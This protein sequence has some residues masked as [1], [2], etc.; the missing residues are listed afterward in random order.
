ML[1]MPKEEPQQA[2]V[3]VA[4]LRWGI[5]TSSTLTGSDAQ[6]LCIVGQ[7]ALLGCFTGVGQQINW[8]LYGIL[9]VQCCGRSRLVA[10]LWTRCCRLWL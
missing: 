8:Q 2:V 3:D 5:T 10:T 7:C 1:V 4:Y 9:D 6:A